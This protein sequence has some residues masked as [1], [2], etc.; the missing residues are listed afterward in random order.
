MHHG[1]CLNDPPLLDLP[2]HQVGIARVKVARRSAHHLLHIVLGFAVRPRGLLVEVLRINGR[3]GPQDLGVVGLHSLVHHLVLVW[4]D[5]LDRTVYASQFLRVHVRILLCHT[6]LIF[7]LSC[8]SIVI[9]GEEV[10]FSIV[11]LV[12]HGLIALF[13]LKA[14]RV[15]SRFELSIVW[16]RLLISSCIV[17]VKSNSKVA[18]LSLV[19]RRRSVAILLIIILVLVVVLVI[20][21]GLRD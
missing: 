10:G 19:D 11:A 3:G 9:E 13:V 7:S 20:V 4:R 1:L 18:A 16:L 15:A 2:L 5:L 12:R 8:S 6:H 17:L 14:S 21:L